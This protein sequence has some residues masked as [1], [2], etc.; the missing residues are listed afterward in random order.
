MNE[1]LNPALVTVWRSNLGACLG[2]MPINAAVCPQAIASSEKHANLT[3]ESASDWTFN[4]FWAK[5]GSKV[6]WGECSW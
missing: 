3:A 2:Q 1:N 6:E 4:V 5:R